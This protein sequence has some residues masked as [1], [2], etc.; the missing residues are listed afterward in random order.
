MSGDSGGICS[1]LGAV[2]VA[3]I[4]TQCCI[5]MVMKC[6]WMG[7]CRHRSTNSHHTSTKLALEHAHVMG[8]RMVSPSV[9]G[10]TQCFLMAGSN[11]PL[12]CFLGQNSP[13]AC[14]LT[15]PTLKKCIICCGPHDA[16]LTG[17]SL[18]PCMPIFDQGL[19]T[20]GYVNECRR[21]HVECKKC[22]SSRH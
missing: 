16:R 14:F 11:E 13:R 8:Y 2:M 3:P 6:A 9:W 7:F 15:I 10:Y 18:T 21:A 17:V 1:V 5:F 22:P 20:C 12:S 4:G 19:V